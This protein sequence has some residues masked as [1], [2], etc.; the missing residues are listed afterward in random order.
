[1][2]GV[3]SGQPKPIR[4]EPSPMS[5]R[6]FRVFLPLFLACYVVAGFLTHSRFGGRKVFPFFSWSLYSGTSRQIVQ[7]TALLLEVDGRPLGTGVDLVTTPAFHRSPDYWLDAG[8][9]GN[10]GQALEAGDRKRAEALRRLVEA[11]IIREDQ[12]RYE[13]VK[14][15]YDPLERRASGVYQETSLG[16]FVKA[17]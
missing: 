7:Y 2:P 9:L 13:M 5:S 15:T 4:T 17:R 1:M 14:R 11:N 12:V 10:F 8:V 3:W 16:I 6:S